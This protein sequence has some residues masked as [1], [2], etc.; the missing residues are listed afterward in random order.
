M[1]SRLSGGNKVT[2][3]SDIVIV[4]QDFGAP[5]TE[6]DSPPQQ[7][8]GPRGHTAPPWQRPAINAPKG[9]VHEQVRATPEFAQLRRRTR[10]FAFPVTVAFL[11]WYLVYVLM[12]SY[13]R[14][15]MATPVLG[16]VNLGLVIGL[17]QFVTT[18][19]IATVSVRHARRRID[20]LAD[21]IR[22]RLEGHD[23]R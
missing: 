8:F 13:A 20:P 11:L 4:P 23:G 2:M 22:V 12:A 14:D 19:V 3:R 15:F 9:T 7:R 5:M 16:A 17:L 21:Q 18:F 10:G 1:G 6:Q